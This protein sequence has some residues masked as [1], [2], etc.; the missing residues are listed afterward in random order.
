MQFIS[1]KERTEAHGHI[2]N[3]GGKIKSWTNGFGAIVTLPSQQ[4]GGLDEASSD[5]I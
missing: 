1:Q 5:P 3:F 4:I 2:N